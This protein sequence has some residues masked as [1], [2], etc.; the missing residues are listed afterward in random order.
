MKKYLTVHYGGW[1]NAKKLI[2][3]LTF[4]MHCAREQER[5]KRKLDKAYAL[6]SLK[7]LTDDRSAKLAVLVAAMPSVPV[8]AQRTYP[9]KPFKKDGTLSVHG[10]KWRH[11][12]KQ[13]NLPENFTGVI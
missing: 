5:T 4:K 7:K 8:Y 13:Q 6:E 12:L 1:D 9:S 11:L 10:V 3:N 2:E